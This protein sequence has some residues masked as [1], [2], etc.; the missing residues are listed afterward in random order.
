MPQVE[1]RNVLLR[2]KDALVVD[3]RWIRFYIP[4]WK[5]FGG[6]GK[7]GVRLNPA[8]YSS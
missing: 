3:I 8:A 1:Y 6:I 7:L 5:E 2:V 4:Y